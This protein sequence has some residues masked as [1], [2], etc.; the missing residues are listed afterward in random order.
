MSLVVCVSVC[1]FFCVLLFSCFIC[2]CTCLCVCLLVY[3]CLRV[4]VCLCVCL[5]FMFEFLLFM[6]LFVR[7]LHS[8]RWCLFI[9]ASS[10]HKLHV[11][12]GRQLI[13]HRCSARQSWPVFILNREGY[14]SFSW[15]V[16]EIGSVSDVL[17]QLVS[18]IMDEI[19]WSEMINYH[20]FAINK[21]TRRCTMW[22]LLLISHV[23]Q[24]MFEVFLIPSALVLTLLMKRPILNSLF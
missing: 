1:V 16:E 2:L 10:S 11:G 12:V 13:L 19:K 20:L 24:F 21:P 4:Y 23:L 5:L 18:M 6:S 7:L 22:L 17:I 14:C 3:V 9:M 8:P 15:H